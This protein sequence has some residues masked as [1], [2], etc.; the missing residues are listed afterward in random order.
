MAKLTL[1]DVSNITGAESA[2]ISTL[3]NNSSLV[4]AALENT[5]SRDGTTPNQM[6]ADFDMNSNDI[7]NVGSIAAKDFTIAGSSVTGAVQTAVDAANSAKQFAEQAS[8]AETL[9]EVASDLIL[10]DSYEQLESDNTLIGYAGTGAVRIV[11]AGEVVRA[12]SREYRVTESGNTSPYVTTAGGVKLDLI[13]QGLDIVSGQEHLAAWYNDLRNHTFDLE[14]TGTT[15]SAIGFFLGDSKVAGT[16]VSARGRLDAMLDFEAGR[17]SNTFVDFGAFGYG[18]EDSVD[19]DTNRLDELM[20]HPGF[21]DC[22]LVI[23]N[24]GTNEQVTP[25]RTIGETEAALRSI[26]AKLRDTTRTPAGK[27]AN[28]LSILIMGQTTANNDSPSHLQNESLMRR[29][30]ALYADVAR[31]TQCAFI[32]CYSLFKE[33][34]NNASWMDTVTTLGNSQIHPGDRFNGALVS[35]ISEILFPTALRAIAGTSPNNYHDAVRKFPSTATLTQTSLPS[36]FPYGDSSWRAIT[37]G[38]HWPLDGIVI[39]HRNASRVTTQWNYS[40]LTGEVQV[41]TSV[42]ATNTWNEWRSL[43]AYSA[44]AEVSPAAGFTLPSAE[45]MKTLSDGKVARGQ[46]YVNKSA[47]GTITSGTV[48]CTLPV[49]A[50]PTEFQWG[51]FVGAFASGQP[52]QTPFTQISPAGVVTIQEDVTSTASRVYLVGLNWIL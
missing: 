45:K 19:M 51:R 24:F 9:L 37:T 43:S 5:L 16:N 13:E 41:R 20:S 7:L 8:I 47:P 25:A 14:T 33:A 39:A 35:K 49:N 27:T 15:T 3:N 36:D 6:N 48:I 1:N 2:A 26:I 52:W 46:G 17:T 32:D 28:E 4:E 44:Q 42:G 38:G 23:L 29:L 40:R 10:F 18:G 31:D 11:A 22:S 30:A 50:R 12:G 34:H 21:A